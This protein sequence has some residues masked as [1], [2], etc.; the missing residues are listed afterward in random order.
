MGLYDIGMKA[1]GDAV[2]VGL[3]MLLEGHND[4]RQ[5][6][7][8]EK[9][10]NLQI[11]GNKEMGRFNQ[12]LAYDM[13]LKTGAVGQME[14]LRKA[15]LNPGLMYGMG[16]AGGATTSGGGGGGSVSGGNAP[17]GGQE[18]M[19]LMMQKAQLENMKAQKENIEADTLNKR[20]Q[21]PNITIEGENKAAG[22][23]NIKADTENKK[24]QSAMM[25]I[26]NKIA[27][28]SMENSINT[29]RVEYLKRDQELQAAVRNNS[30]DQ[31]TYNEKIEQIKA[32]LA[33]TLAETKLREANIGLNQ[34]QVKEI[35]KK[36]EL[37]S[38]DLSWKDIEQEDRHAR[39]QAEIKSI[40]NSINM[41]D[42]PNS[43]KA[44]T[45]IAEGVLQAIMLK[46]AL[47]PVPTRNPVGFKP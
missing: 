21:N 39:I 31:A 36:I 11:T 40:T 8:Q 24:L 12:E 17:G 19:G 14:Q 25:K 35:A 3:G 1:A 13:W 15:G 29:I 2:D 33:N 23:E 42:T 45:D 5:L 9:L 46:G 30:I 6:R 47:S 18:I 28:D 41:N 44:I 16:G 37:M 10:Q 34:E 38:N 43:Q 4:R 7:Q 27:G 20:S 22:T 26:Q 32:N